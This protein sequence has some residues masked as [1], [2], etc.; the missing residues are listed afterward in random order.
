M[1]KNPKK[2]ETER[3]NINE[4]ISNTSSNSRKFSP[5][6]ERNILGRSERVP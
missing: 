2:K 4:N 1:N 5:T 3:N 6:S